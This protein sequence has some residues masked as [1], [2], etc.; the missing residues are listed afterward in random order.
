MN[1]HFGVREICLDTLATSDVP[2]FDNPSIITGD[3]PRGVLEVVYSYNLRGVAQE[4]SSLRNILVDK[5]PQNHVT[6][7]I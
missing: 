3:Q 4:F 7:G 1:D 5:S 6:F 2:S